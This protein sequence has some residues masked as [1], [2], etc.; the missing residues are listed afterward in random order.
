MIRGWE[1]RAKKAGGGEATPRTAHW[2]LVPPA[3]RDEELEA[4]GRAALVARRKKLRD[5]DHLIFQDFWGVKEA[6]YYMS[7]PLDAARPDQAQQGRIGM[8]GG[9]ARQCS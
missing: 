5:G 1:R 6:T 9:D 2:I 7:E 4:A 8:I 3:L